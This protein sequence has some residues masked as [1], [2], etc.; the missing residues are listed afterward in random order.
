MGERGQP[1]EDEV[2]YEAGPETERPA[3]SPPETSCFLAESD[4]HFPGNVLV[5]APRH[6]SET[7]K[8]KFNRL[9]S[10]LYFLHEQIDLE[11]QVSADHDLMFRCSGVRGHRV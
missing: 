8:E 3:E 7:N 5:S 10:E 6:D 9:K 2:V 1:S 11:R 4:G